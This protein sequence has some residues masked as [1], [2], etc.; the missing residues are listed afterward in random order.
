MSC[1]IFS[2]AKQA[3]VSFSLA[4]GVCMIPVPL[5]PGTSLDKTCLLWCSEDSREN[6]APTVFGWILFLM[7]ICYCF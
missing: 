7:T 3:L 2:S 1:A 4:L 6:S 5:T